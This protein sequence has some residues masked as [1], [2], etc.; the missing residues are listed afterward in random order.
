LVALPSFRNWVHQAAT[1]V[2]LQLRAL[3]GIPTIGP[4]HLAVSP[5]WRSGAHGDFLIPSFIGAE[6][7]WLWEET[8]LVGNDVRVEF[9]LETL[10]SDGILP[11]FSSVNA[12]GAGG[13][14]GIVED[15]GLR[16]PV[17]PHGRRGGAIALDIPFFWFLFLMKLVSTD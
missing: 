17:E 6:R 4:W 12:F 7:C 2:L 3:I 15:R 1:F 9:L 10:S 16:T 8:G 13:A 5:G 14:G 11:A